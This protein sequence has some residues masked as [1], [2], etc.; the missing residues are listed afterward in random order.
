MRFVGNS[1]EWIHLLEITNLVH[2]RVLLPTQTLVATML[3]LFSVVALTHYL[4]M[5]TLQ[6]RLLYIFK[7]PELLVVFFPLKTSSETP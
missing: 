5:D 3:L 7:F 4:S 6:V 1:V 2:E